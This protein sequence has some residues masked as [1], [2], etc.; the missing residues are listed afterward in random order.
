M[1]WPKWIWTWLREL[2]YRAFTPI[3]TVWHIRTLDQRWQQQKA[4]NAILIQK[5]DRVYRHLRLESMLSHAN[6]GTNRNKKCSCG[7]GKKYKNCCA[8]KGKKGG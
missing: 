3:A 7:S 6:R 5:M 8:P 1:T 4:L 2:V